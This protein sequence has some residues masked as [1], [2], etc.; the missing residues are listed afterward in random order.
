MPADQVKNEVVLSKFD[1][2]FVQNKN[3]IMHECSIF[4]QRSQ[5][6][7]GTVEAYMRAWYEL[8][9]NTPWWDFIR[10]ELV[11]V[12]SECQ[13][14]E[15]LQLTRDLKLETAIEMARE[16]E[17]IENQA[18]AQH[19]AASVKQSYTKQPRGKPRGPSGQHDRGKSTNNNRISLEFAVDVVLRVHDLIIN[20]RCQ[21]RDS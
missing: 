10:D 21:A 16:H 7:G 17:L 14:S 6:L 19:S 13:L 12:L 3:I 9:R 4:N 8:S 5:Q 11:I 20:N 15:K 1:E 2:H 18:K